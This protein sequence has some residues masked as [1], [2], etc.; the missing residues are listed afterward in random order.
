MALVGAAL[1][2]R[3]PK[4]PPQDVISKIVLLV[5][6]LNLLCIATVTALFVALITFFPGLSFTTALAWMLGILVLAAWACYMLGR[7]IQLDDL[8]SA[9][10]LP[11][12]ET[13]K[14]LVKAF[15]RGWTRS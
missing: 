9:P 11:G 2:P 4:A 3:P 1:Q 13:A 7:T 8:I 10:N 15:R 12:M 6:A 5:V 14:N